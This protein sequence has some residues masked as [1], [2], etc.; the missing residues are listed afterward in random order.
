MVPGLLISLAVGY[1][2]LLLAKR[3]TKPLNRIGKV[4]GWLIMTVAFTGLICIAV[5]SLCRM[6][7]SKRVKPAVMCPFGGPKV[8]ILPP[9]SG[10]HRREPGE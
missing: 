6:C 8:D 9:E 5:S 2:V 10:D 1:G 3:E 4:V 7:P